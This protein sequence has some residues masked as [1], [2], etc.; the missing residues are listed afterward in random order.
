MLDA[1]LTPLQN[2]LDSVLGNS[3][4]RPP[5]SIIEQIVNVHEQS[6]PQLWQAALDSHPASQKLKH[7]FTQIYNDYIIEMEHSQAQQLLDA[8]IIPGARFTDIATDDALAAYTRVSDLFEYVDFSNIKNVVML[9][10]GK[11]PVTALHIIDRTEVSR[12]TCIDILPTAVLTAEKLGEQ[13]GWSKIEF[14]CTDGLE[15]DYSLADFIYVANMVRPKSAILAQIFQT[16]RP[17]A[18]IVVREPYGLGHLWAETCLEAL[19]EHTEYKVK[20]YGKGSRF[21]SYDMYLSNNK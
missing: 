20:G 6:S 21:L 15:F 19:Q 9:G 14:T 13:L 7:T 17:D 18:S 16:A 12:V 5:K 10:C 2:T 1:Q 8:S 3:K 11:L 4:G